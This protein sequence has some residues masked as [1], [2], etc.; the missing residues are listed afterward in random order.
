MIGF[1]KEQSTA[2]NFC[3]QCVRNC[4]YAT[5]YGECAKAPS[6]FCV[7][8]IVSNGAHDELRKKPKKH[9][10]KNCAYCMLKSGFC[11]VRE[12]IDA[13]PINNKNDC[14]YFKEV[15]E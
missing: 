6:Y 1:S 7:H 2:G 5:E 8:R 15:I 12:Y 9:S 11:K 4:I 13:Y 10:C 14:E 3:N